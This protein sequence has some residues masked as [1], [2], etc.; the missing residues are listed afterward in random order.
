MPEA[1]ALIARLI[2]QRPLCA[3]CIAERTGLSSLDLEPYFARI[4]AAITMFREDS[5]RC[6]ACGS[7]GKVYSLDLGPPG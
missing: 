5:D 4:R 6:R 2:V 7:V 1:I 3:D